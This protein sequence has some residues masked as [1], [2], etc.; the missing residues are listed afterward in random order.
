MPY[1]YPVRIGFIGPGLMGSHMIHNLVAAGHEVRVYARTPAR[2]SGLPAPLAGSVAEAVAGCDAAC[3]MVTDSA[4]VVEVVEQVLAADPPPP[5]IVDFST[6]APSVARDLS[7][8]ARRRGIGY[9]DAPV[10]GG[11]AG[12]RAGSLAVMVG[13]AAADLEAA[14]PILDAVGDPAKRV[15]C[16]PAGSGL[17]VKL[18]NNLLVGVISAATAE[19]LGIGQRA[20]VP[21]EVMAR[22]VGASSGSSWWLENMLPGHLQGEHEAGFKAR[23]LRKD[24]G[25]ARDLAGDDLRVAAEAIAQ[26]EG[27]PDELDY[28]AVTRRFLELP[29]EDPLAG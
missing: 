29:G 16:G 11:P 3:S 17:V 6:I 27:I 5:L 19:A 14:A 2:A 13:G 23:D 1:E 22:A 9:L 15:H 12:A 18:V 25:H 26:F 21:L 28:G 10:S 4:D 7:E 24:L 20:G 8:R